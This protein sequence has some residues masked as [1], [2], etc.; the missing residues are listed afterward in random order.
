MRRIV[1]AVWA[2]VLLAACA[3]QGSVREDLVAGSEFAGLPADAQAYVTV[4]V[5]RSRELLDD[6]L[7]VSGL[8]GKTVKTFLDKTF[9][10]SAALYFRADRS[11]RTY[12]LASSG[13]NYPA[14]A[15]DFSF[16][17]SP[18]W[19]KTRSATGKKYWHSVKSRI[20]LS[21]QRNKAYISDGDPFFD[22]NDA[23]P[24]AG[25]K[26]FSG[27]SPLSAWITDMSPLNKTL[28][29]LDIPVTVPADALYMAAFE[30]EN[31]WQAVFRMETPSAAQARGL[32]SVLSMVRAASA[33]GYIKDATAIKFVSLLLSETPSVDGAAL[34]LKSPVMAQ[35]EFAALI[36]SLR[37][38][39]PGLT[40]P[41]M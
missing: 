33:R 41:K 6:V 31:G 16:F 13:R 18:S 35:A 26:L 19:K 28:E 5:E 23:V 11:G 4:D 20:S 7:A 22:G 37:A 34:I 32:V 36:A 10:A 40:Q 39:T 30:K 8:G 1:L 2:G 15:S 21:I 17:F 12:L 38:A 29:R 25:F 14:A 24:P 3:G 9:S 27:G